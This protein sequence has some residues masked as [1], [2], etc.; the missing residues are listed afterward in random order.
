M[1]CIKKKKSF[2]YYPIIWREDD[3]ISNA[4]NL[5]IFFSALKIL[6]NHLVKNENLFEESQLVK[7]T[8]VNYFT[9]LYVSELDMHALFAF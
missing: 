3:Q 1:A 8:K 9:K 6:F 2:K 4:K 7:K 5:T